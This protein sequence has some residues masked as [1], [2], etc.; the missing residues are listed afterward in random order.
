MSHVSTVVVAPIPTYI[1]IF[2]VI[3][4]IELESERRWV[5]CLKVDMGSMPLASLVATLRPHCSASDF[6]FQVAHEVARVLVVV[7]CGCGNAV[8]R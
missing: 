6:H 2:E 1:L 5:G 7:L 8:R 4:N 3:P